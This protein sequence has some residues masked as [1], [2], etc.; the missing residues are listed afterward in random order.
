MRIAVLVENDR[1]R[2]DL[3]AAHGLCL[4]LETGEDRILFDFGPDGRFIENARKMGI[5]L[6]EVNLAVLSHGHQD[7]GGGLPDFLSFNVKAPVYLHPESLMK[8]YS[9]QEDGIMKDIGI[10]KEIRESRRLIPVE[11]VS[12]INDRMALISYVKG[13]E[14]LPPGNETLFMEKEGEIRPDDFLHEQSLLMEEEGKLYL[15]SGCGHRGIVNLME[16]V[17]ELRGRYPD[18]VIGGFHIKKPSKISHDAGYVMK[19]G[20][21]LLETG[22]QF[23]TCHCTGPKMFKK[24]KETMGGSISYVVTGS[25]ISI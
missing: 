20:E 19:L 11:G 12:W 15:I 4:Y 16:T 25:D 17:R 24:L 13:V 2:E 6:H 21:M 23:H 3:S 8:H 18:H 9:R 7:H 14:M 5:D 1:E 10:P 22:S